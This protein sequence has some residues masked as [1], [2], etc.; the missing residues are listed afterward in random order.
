MAPSMS[1]KKVMECKPSYLNMLAQLL[2][3]LVCW[4][5]SA[6]PHIASAQ[7]P[8]DISK[9]NAEILAAE[10]AKGAALV[11]LVKKNDRGQL[12][13]RLRAGS[14]PNAFYPY[15]GSLMHIAADYGD[16]P[17]MDLLL[18]YGGKIS[19]APADGFTPFLAAASRRDGAFLG[20]ML[21]KGVSLNE[22]DRD[23]N[24]ALRV[25]VTSAN[26]KGVRFLLS[27]SMDANE[28][29]GTLKTTLLADAVLSNCMDCVLALRE[30]KAKDNRSDGE[31]NSVAAICKNATGAFAATCTAA[32]K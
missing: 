11:G 17:T 2:V 4:A 29:G 24:N 32:T 28:I 8:G 30:A 9:T 21:Q 25:A 13:R 26:A 19:N 20:Y 16:M 31:A 27:Q 10:A 1:Y 5:M 15:A 6:Q 12:E 14:N 7:V 3:C 23:G 22:R 18:R